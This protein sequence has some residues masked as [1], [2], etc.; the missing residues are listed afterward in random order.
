MQKIINK[1]NEMTKEEMKELLKKTAIKTGLVF[2]GIV[3]GKNLRNKQYEKD[4]YYLNENLE[5]MES[6]NFYLEEVIDR[7]T[8]KI[9]EYID[10][11][12][13]KDKLIGNLKNGVLERDL[14]IMELVDGNT[15]RYRGI[16]SNIFTTD[17]LID[18]SSRLDKETIIAKTNYQVYLTK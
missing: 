11:T 6:D 14:S 1:Y 3:I 17:E 13:Y 4:I 10:S 2:T 5:C 7:Q 8:L 15:D 12:M 18:N 16:R 9:K